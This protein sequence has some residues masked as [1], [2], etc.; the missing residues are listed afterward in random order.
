MTSGTSETG[1]DTLSSRT[2]GPRP[3]RLDVAKGPEVRPRA[4]RKVGSVGRTRQVET[5]ELA[6][7]VDGD[8][9]RE[10]P[11]RSPA[12]MDDLGLPQPLPAVENIEPITLQQPGAQRPVH[13]LLEG[14]A[15]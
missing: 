11:G 6:D 12:R 7:A 14:R 5:S 13:R 2:K 8:V 3:R 15:R 9:H 1:I 10:L 4:R